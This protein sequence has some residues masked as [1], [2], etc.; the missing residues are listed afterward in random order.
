MNPKD[1]LK[2]LE[3]ALQ[4]INA[5]AKELGL[6]F[7][8]MFFEI[9]P[10]DIIYTFGAYG[11]PTRYSHWT[12]GKAYHKMKTQYDYNLGRIYEMVIN[13]NPCYAFLLEGNSIIQNKLV[14]AHVLAHCD[15]FKNNA[16]FKNTSRDMVESMAAA[17]ERFREY[18]FKHGRAKVELFI[19]AALSIQEHIEP[20][21]MI[22]KGEELRKRRQNEHKRANYAEHPETPYDDLWELEEVRKDAS[23][24]EKEKKFPKEPEKDLML[25]IIEH[26]K[27]LEDW[28]RDIMSVIRQEMFYFWPQME[29]K[30]MNEG[31]ATYWHL[32]IMRDIHLD[33]NETIEFAKM[34]S[35][36]IQTSR[37]RI[38]PYTLGLKIFEDIEKRWDNPT[39]E[40]KERYGR[41]GGEG[42]EKIFEVRANE[43]DVSF[44]RNY[45]TKELIEEMDLYLYKKVG[46]E[47]R[48]D[49]KDWEKVRDG[50]VAGLTNGGYPYIT[51]QNGDYNKNGELYLKHHYEGTELDVYYVE[52]TL[53]YLYSLWGHTIH[54]ETVLDN[55][56][57]LFSFNGE[58]SSKKFM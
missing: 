19:D 55:K 40:E 2:I 44:L 47:W 27:E 26:S 3:D 36:I 18:E 15:F 25:F 8:N 38:N 43:N 9:C 56:S 48:V 46:N 41:S 17:S 45:L 53:P 37:T 57:V 52:K 51:V 54:L 4:V 7:Y 14:M 23:A 10:A 30:I 11:M 49:E 29:T 12:F 6:D 16:Y 5:K 50:L 35:G 20:R 58:K 28:Q 24:D 39:S 1:E 32:R 22:R 42:K 31:W 13:S 21:I 34:H 33:V